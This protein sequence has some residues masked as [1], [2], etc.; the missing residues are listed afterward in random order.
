MINA[1]QKAVL[2]SMTSSERW[3]EQKYTFDKTPSPQAD[4]CVWPDSLR[5]DVVGFG[6]TFNEPYAESVG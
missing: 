6:G 3:I 4:I 2:Y 5:Q 1:A